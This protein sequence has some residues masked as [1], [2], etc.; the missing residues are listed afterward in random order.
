MITAAMARDLLIAIVLVVILNAALTGS[1]RR[2]VRATTPQS[3]LGYSS[4]GTDA[5]S[6]RAADRCAAF[7]FVDRR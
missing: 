7:L 6:C 4:L 5:A 3:G 2:D 1:N